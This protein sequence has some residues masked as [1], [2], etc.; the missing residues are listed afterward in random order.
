MNDIYKK[1]NNWIGYNKLDNFNKDM[2]KYKN[3]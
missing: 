1:D 3:I 2:L